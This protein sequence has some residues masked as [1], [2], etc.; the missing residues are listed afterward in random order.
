MGLGLLLRRDEYGVFQR[1]SGTVNYSYD[2]PFNDDNHLAFGLGLGFVDTRI[3]MSGVSNNLEGT[4]G[5]QGEQA[6]VI[7]DYKGV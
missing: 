4:I 3:P 5:G 6:G 2:V 7:D 1:T